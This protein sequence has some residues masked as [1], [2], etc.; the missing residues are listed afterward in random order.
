MQMLSLECTAIPRNNRLQT[1]EVRLP[2]RKGAAYRETMKSDMRRQ[3]WRVCDYI[4]PSLYGWHEWIL[5]GS[6]GI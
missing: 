1:L 2:C 4:C 3:P 5:V 6:P